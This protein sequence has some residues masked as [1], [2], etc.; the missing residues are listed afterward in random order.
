[1]NGKPVG[2]MSNA[3]SYL[4]IDRTWRKGDRI[5]LTFPMDLHIDCLPDA[6]DTCAILYGPV[7]LAGKLGRTDIAPDIEYGRYGPYDSKP[8]AVPTLDLSLGSAGIISS[9]N[10]E[11]RV[12]TAKSTDNNK[13]ELV[14]FY[15]L[16][17]ERYAIYWP[18]AKR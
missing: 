14:P 3:G 7:V 4:T 2:Q 17:G 8:V 10:G 6:P 18:T 1:V 11:S 15:R 9:G 12:F 16:Y 5:E 13:V